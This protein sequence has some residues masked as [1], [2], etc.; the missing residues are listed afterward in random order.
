MTVEIEQAETRDVAQDEN[1]VKKPD[2]L[3]DYG[4]LSNHASWTFRQTVTR[5]RK[6]M[7]IC[8]GAGICAMGDGYQFK[9]PGNIV[10]LRGFINQMGSPNA[11]GV[12]VLN[13]QHVAAWG[14]RCPHMLVNQN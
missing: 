6:A 3:L 11:S 7:L 12:Y 2:A 1:D 5:F 4:D 9:M 14:G 13:P 8:F 10:A